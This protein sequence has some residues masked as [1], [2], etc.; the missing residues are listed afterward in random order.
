MAALPLLKPS[1]RPDEL[2]PLTVDQYHREPDAAIVAGTPC[3]Y[4][5]YHPGQ[6]SFCKSCPSE[7]RWNPALLPGG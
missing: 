5:D 4:A 2:A 6:L 7:V 1:F 3:D